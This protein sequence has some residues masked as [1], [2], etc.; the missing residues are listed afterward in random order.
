MHDSFV[1]CFAG[2]IWSCFGLVMFSF[3]VFCFRFD[4]PTKGCKPKGVKWSVY[5]LSV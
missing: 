1:Y 5:K 2:M 4:L 3:S